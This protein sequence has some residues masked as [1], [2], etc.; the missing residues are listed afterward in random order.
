MGL[1]PMP[2]S[3]SLYRF[4]EESIFVHITEKEKVISFDITLL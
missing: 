2:Q 3:F 4:S 1:C